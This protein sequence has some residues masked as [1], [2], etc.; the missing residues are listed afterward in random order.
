MSHYLL[1][2]R[3]FPPE[4]SFPY[5]GACLLL[6]VWGR[7]WAQ[8]WIH[9]H[10]TK[11]AYPSPSLFCLATRC[12]VIFQQFMALNSAPVLCVMRVCVCSSSHARSTSITTSVPPSLTFQPLHPASFKSACNYLIWTN[13]RAEV[14]KKESVVLVGAEAVSPTAVPFILNRFPSFS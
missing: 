10:A 9:W 3:L 14:G 8:P 2:E 5:F 7:C 6:S 11:H 1:K 4:W 12:Q 13:Y